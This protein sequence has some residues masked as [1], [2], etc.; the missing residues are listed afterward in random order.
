MPAAPE[1]SERGSAAVEFALVLPLALV[2][3]LGLVQ[4]G[5]FARDRLLV[6]AA[7]R[8]GARTAAVTEDLE[9]A[10][11]AAH[12]AAPALDEPHLTIDVVRVGTRGDPVSVHVTYVDPVRVPFVGW[13]IADG[14]TFSTT[15][16]A[17]QEFG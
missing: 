11:A 6:E 5:I 10:R 8:A 1:R 15:T 13:L 14:V 12:A 17:R 4:V 9:A 2:L 7:A 3:V 16:V